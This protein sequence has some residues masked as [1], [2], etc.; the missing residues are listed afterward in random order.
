MQCKQAVVVDEHT[1]GVVLKNGEIQILHASKLRGA[2]I[3]HG[4]LFP[5]QRIV[6]AATMHD[7]NSYRVLYNSS[8]ILG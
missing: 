8:W 4:T 6:R 5:E 1:L 3:E 2:I 7:F